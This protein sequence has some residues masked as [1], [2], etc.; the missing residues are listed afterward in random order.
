MTLYFRKAGVVCAVFLIAASVIVGADKPKSVILV[1]SDGTG[2][3][4]ITSLRYAEEDFQFSRFSVVGLFT[5][6][7]NDK[8]ITDSAAGG[9]AFATGQKTNNGMVAMLPDGTRIQTVLELVEKQGKATGLVATSQITHATPATFSAHVEDRDNEM[10]IARQQAVAG[11]EV[12]LG[13]GQQFFAENDSGDLTKQ[14]QED[15]YR[16]ISTKQTLESVNT[17]STK[18][19]IGLFAKKGMP[20]ASKR[21]ISLAQMT[22]TATEILDNDEDGF[23]LMV[24]ASQVDWAG[25]DNDGPEVVAEMQDMNSALKWM[26]DYRESHPDVLVLWVSDHETG[27]MAIGYGVSG[28]EREGVNV[29]YGPTA[30][31]GRMEFGWTSDGHTGQMIPAFAIGPGAEHFSGVYDNTDIGKRLFKLLRSD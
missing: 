11:I 15:G 26:L 30:Q 10:E 28:H 19:L 21:D 3:S 17:Q 6:H 31:K 24:E 5:T 8:L 12:M 14:M 20:T 27:G 4:Q 7:A 16:Y 2:V 13:G 18:K 29:D 1:I 22:Q 23:F 25:H 9:T